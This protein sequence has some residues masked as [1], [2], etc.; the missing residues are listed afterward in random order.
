MKAY[1]TLKELEGQLCV[2]KPI[3]EKDKKH[4]NVCISFKVGSCAI[5]LSKYDKISK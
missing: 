2:S 5:S 3:Y 4:E 1:V